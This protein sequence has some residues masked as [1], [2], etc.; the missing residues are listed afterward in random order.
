MRLRIHC[1]H[2]LGSL[3][4]KMQSVWR[5]TRTKA[6]RHSF[7]QRLHASELKGNWR[8]AGNVDRKMKQKSSLQRTVTNQ[9]R[10]PLDA[11]GVPLVVVDSV[12]IKGQC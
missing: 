3:D 12:A 1:L 4:P 2:A 9:S 8:R 10:V 5:F 6:E 11:G 7:K